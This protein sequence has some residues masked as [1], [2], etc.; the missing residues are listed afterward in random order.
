MG[1]CESE[2]EFMVADPIAFHR[3]V[4]C[5]TGKDQPLIQYCFDPRRHLRHSGREP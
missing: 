1:G 4:P 5:Y 3:P 2:K